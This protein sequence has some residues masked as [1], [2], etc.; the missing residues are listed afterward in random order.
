M[1]TAES[2][3][4]GTSP[5]SAPSTVVGVV[6]FVAWGIAAII[7]VASTIN[8]AAD[9]E[10][11]A[12]ITA[13]ATLALMTLLAVMEGGEVAVIDRWKVMYPERSRSQL[14]GWLAAR[15][16]FVAL[17]VTTATLLANRSEVTVPGTGVS[18]DE[19]VPL[20]VFDICFVGILR[21]CGSL[22]SSRSISQRPIPTGI[23]RTYVGLCSRSSR[24]WTRAAS[25]SRA[26]GPRRQSSAVS[27]GRS[28]RP[29]RCRRR[30]CRAR[31][32]WVTSGAS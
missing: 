31:I 15:Q 12:I 27:A 30:S 13:V 5:R 7:W 20:R 18:F 29:R 1:T 2:R 22:R 3:E 25:R 26:H 9:G 6:L 11:M 32:R 16:L 10:S 21:S 8:L 14:A 19:D 17:I 24:S 23:S 28:R 4:E